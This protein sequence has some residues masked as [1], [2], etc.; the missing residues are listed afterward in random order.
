MKILAGILG[1]RLDEKV[2]FFKGEYKV[3]KRV[4]L[5]IK[6]YK[7]KIIAIFLCIIIS[8][9][10]NILVPFI[11]KEIIDKGLVSQDFRVIIKFSLGVFLLVIVDQGIGLFQTKYYAY[12]NSMFRYTLSKNAFKHVLKLKM[13]YFNNVNFAEIMNNLNIDIANIASI[14]DRGTFLIINQVF[15]FI[16]GLIGLMIISWKL[17]VIVICMVPIRYFLVKYLAQKRMSLFQQYIDCNREFSAWYGDTISGVKEIKLWGADRL[18]LGQFINKN[19]KIMKLNIKI[20]F[21]DKLNE[22]SET[23]LFQ[24]IT[25]SIYIIGALLLFHHDFTIGSLF[26]FITYSVYVTMPISAI[27]NI[28]YSFSSVI[29]STNRFCEFLDMETEF[30]KSNEKMLKI[31]KDEEFNIKFENVN[32]SY[33]KGQKLLSNVNFEI[34]QGEKVALIGSNGSGKSTCINLILRLFKPTSGKILLNGKDINLFKLRDYRELISVVNQDLYLFN[35]TIEDNIMLS[36]K[37][38]E[39]LIYKAAKESGASEF[40]DKIPKKY[41]SKVGRNG[42]KLSSGQRQKIAVARAFARDSIVFIFDEATANFDKESEKYLSDL[43]NINYK[44]KT[45]IVICHNQRLLKKVDKIIVLENGEILE[46]GSY[47]EL[48][49]KNIINRVI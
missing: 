2:I 34:R 36:S 37:N 45:I 46:V 21:M 5:L 1:I 20:I 38:N 3:L 12:L 43:I 18:K 49:A 7:K 16:G 10:I 25:S 4:L 42:S 26:A 19:R 32:F 48:Y 47:E 8:S 40:I 30:E 11:S 31:V 29:P 28:G 9:G 24:F 23:I 6:P 17:T 27:L 15:K 39:C 35:S 13:Q 33:K 22:F 44:D 41:K 14:L